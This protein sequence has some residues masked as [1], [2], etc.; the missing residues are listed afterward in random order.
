MLALPSLP[1][2]CSHGGAH[3]RVKAFTESRGWRFAPVYFVNQQ[4]AND[5]KRLWKI[6]VKIRADAV[7]VLTHLVLAGTA[8][9]ARGAHRWPRV[10]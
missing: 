6:Q 1:V 9:P 3:S 10:S 8:L 7:W 2:P 5:W 4:D